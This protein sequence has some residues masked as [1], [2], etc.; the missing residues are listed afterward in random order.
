MEIPIL[1]CI[2]RR[3]CESFCRF[4]NP[5]PSDLQGQRCNV[6]HL[7]HRRDGRGA[8][9]SLRMFGSRQ[10]FRYRVPITFVQVHVAG[11]YVQ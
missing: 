3:F 11:R 4:L 1:R 2:A 10:D 8:G 7:L 6:T 5:D 9:S